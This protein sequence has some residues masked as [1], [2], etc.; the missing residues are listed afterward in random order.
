MPVC[1][2]A[3]QGPYPLFQDA[4]AGSGRSAALSAS[5]S[6]SGVGRQDSASEV[7]EVESTATR[8]RAARRGHGTNV[9]IINR[10]LIPASCNCRQ[11]RKWGL[12]A[13]ERSRGASSAET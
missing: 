1:S 13:P 6:R 10:P 4:G 8:E 11:T 5:Q 2:C 9:L 3:H 7:S 12:Q